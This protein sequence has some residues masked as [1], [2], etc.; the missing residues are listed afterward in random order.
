MT[1][2]ERVKQQFPTLFITLVS[3]LIGIFL[4]DLLAEARSRMNLWPLNWSTLRTWAQISAMVSCAIATWVHYA[5]I[6]ISRRRIATF[7]DSLISF[8][9]P[10]PLLVSNTFVGRDTIWPWY[11]FA[12]GYLVIS[13]ISSVWQIRLALS[14]P[15]LK[16]LQALLRPSGSAAIILLGIPFFALMGFLDARHLL[17]LPME[18]LAAMTPTPAALIFGWLFVH[19]W[20]T[21]IVATAESSG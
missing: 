3:V 11:F 15:E 20:Q 16:P 19:N 5:H 9:V 7:A 14:E 18:T 10:L 4:A 2:E 12:S 6:G 17:S 21:A 13:A 1:V 8:A